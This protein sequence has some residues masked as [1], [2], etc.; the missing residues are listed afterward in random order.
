ME[1]LTLTPESVRS[2]TLVLFDDH[3]PMCTFQSRLLTRLDWL[4]RI[5]FLPI[6]DPR[7]ATL[8]PQLKHEDMM[9]SMHM[10]TPRGKVH[11][12][13]RGIRH[14]AARVPLLWP[15]CL[16]L[17][18]PGTIYVSEFA[19]RWL[20]RNRYLLSKLFGCKTACEILPPKR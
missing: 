14:I 11:Q 16:L 17:W 15:M 2:K 3:C 19:Y 4:R 8:V 12:G 5:E 9:A 18:V 1:S 7:V 13:A 10:L 6:S 20:A